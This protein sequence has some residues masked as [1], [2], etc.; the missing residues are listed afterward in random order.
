MLPSGI[1]HLPEF[2]DRA[3]QEALVEE[4]RLVVAAAPQLVILTLI[5][6]PV[7]GISGV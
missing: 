4:I 7:R 5:G 1:R 3:A 6:L 2:L